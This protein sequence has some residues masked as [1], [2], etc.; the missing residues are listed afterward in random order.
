MFVN[1]LIGHMSCFFGKWLNGALFR[2][3]FAGQPIISGRCILITQDRAD[4]RVR[5]EEGI[6]NK[7]ECLLC[8][9]SKIL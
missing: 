6:N 8:T 2:R 4:W 7:D 3:K 5:T 1:L 9:A